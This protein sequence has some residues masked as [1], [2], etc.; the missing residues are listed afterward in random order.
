MLLAFISDFASWDNS[1]ALHYIDTARKLVKASYRDEIPLLV[2]P[3]SG[4]GA[5]PLEAL[6]LGCYAFASDLNPVACLILASL[7]EEIPRYGV[8]LIDELE[9][10]GKLLQKQIT[11][12]KA[13][14]GMAPPPENGSTNK[15]ISSR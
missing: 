8:E 13:S 3:F 7:L 4:G 9:R 14:S 6:R 11:S 2:D 15:G 1:N 5:I 12:L 10:Q